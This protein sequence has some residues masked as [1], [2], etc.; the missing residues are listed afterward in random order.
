MYM[1]L[2]I[3]SQS[4]L[5]SDSQWTWDVSQMLMIFEDSSCILSAEDF[6]TELSRE[7]GLFNCPSL[8]LKNFIR[9]TEGDHSVWHFPCLDLHDSGYK[10]SDFIFFLFVPLLLHKKV[11]FFNFIFSS[12]IGSN[13]K[14]L[15][16]FAE[17]C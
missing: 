4:R 14:S 10:A 5:R 3:S 15:L 7:F 16:R 12:F 9:K 17:L 11:K 13:F 6:H 8:P 2:K 1:C